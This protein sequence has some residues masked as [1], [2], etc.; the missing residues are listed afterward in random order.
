MCTKKVIPLVGQQQQ[1]PSSQPLGI[2]RNMPS[3][4]AEWITKWGC[5]HW[6][7]IMTGRTGFGVSKRDESHH[8]PPNAEFS[9][10]FLGLGFCFYMCMLSYTLRWPDSALTVSKKFSLFKGSRFFFVFFVMICRMTG[11]ATHFNIFLG[12]LLPAWFAT[13]LPA[14]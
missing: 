8:H 1:Q 6:I 14:A 10:M 7:V 11:A 12:E 13:H 3:K 2:V 9:Y 4:Y 5:V